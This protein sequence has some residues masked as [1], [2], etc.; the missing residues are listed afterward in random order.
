[1]LRGIRASLEEAYL[2]LS[3]L[4]GKQ[5]VPSG[6]T[7]N[8]FLS[9]LRSE[10][11]KMNFEDLLDTVNS[12]LAVPIRFSEAL[13]SMQKTRNCLEHRAGIVGARDA[14]AGGVLVLKFPRFKVY[15]LRNDEE[16]EVVEGA[17]V[18][19]QDGKDEVQILFGID[20]REK[21]VGLNQRIT[22]TLAEFNEIAFACN[23]FVTM[24]ADQIAKQSAKPGT[25]AGSR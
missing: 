19:A 10:A 7:L 21:R 3:M 22:F 8:D 25:A 1:M 18:D 15:Y 4:S 9:G 14:P 17:T 5:R 23:Y 24:L 20:I 16:V 11:D 12:K 13:S 6:T 2:A